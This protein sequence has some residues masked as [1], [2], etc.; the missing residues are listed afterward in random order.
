M[1]NMGAVP[2]SFFLKNI[3]GTGDW[4]HVQTLTDNNVDNPISNVVFYDLTNI[5]SSGYTMDVVSNGVKIRLGGSTQ[6]N[7]ASTTYIYGAWGGQPLTDGAIN[8]GRAK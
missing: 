4:P 2:K 7:G 3:D 5:F 8:Q 6:I 1:I